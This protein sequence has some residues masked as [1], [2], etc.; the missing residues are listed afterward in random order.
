M[1]DNI[2]LQANQSVTF[3]YTLTYVAP[4]LISIA[5]EDINTDSYTDIKTYS[6]DSCQ[7]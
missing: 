4:R 5:L 2:S 6:T 1:V 7:K 3:S